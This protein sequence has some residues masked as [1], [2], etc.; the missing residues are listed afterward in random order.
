MFGRF[1]RVQLQ[2]FTN[3]QYSRA[4][5]GRRPLNEELREVIP[6]WIATLRSCADRQTL[7]HGPRPVVIYVD[8]AG[9]GHL[10]AVVYLDD[11]VLTFSTHCPGWMIDES[12]GIFE[13]ESTASLFGL[14]LEAELCHGRSVILCCDNKAAS[15]TLVRGHSP[16]PVG[17]MIC[18]SFWTL[19]MTFSIPVWVESVAG[20]LN[21]SDPASRGRPG[22]LRLIQVKNKRCE[23][24]KISPNIINSRNS[25]THSQFHLAPGPQ[26][27]CES[28]ACPLPSAESQ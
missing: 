14:A 19:A 17:R 13:L 21:P 15:Q 2:P 20:T 5:K 23:A 3:R 24:P 28:W 27:F 1:G 22:C 18:A 6:R 10:G 9:R 12:A 4:T 8:A 7:V 11:E 26:G 16:T 25:L